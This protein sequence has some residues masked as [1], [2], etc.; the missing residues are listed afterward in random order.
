M[1]F[2]HIRI[3]ILALGHHAYSSNP[4]IAVVASSGTQGRQFQ[5]S[6]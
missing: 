6:F 4:Y 1:Y 3:L 2:K 5:K